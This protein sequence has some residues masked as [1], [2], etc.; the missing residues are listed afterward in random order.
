MDLR[1]TTDPQTF[2]TMS[3]EQLRK[4]FLLDSIFVPGSVQMVY[5]DIDRSITGSVI[6]LL[7]PLQLLSSKR[8]MAA[9]YFAERREIGILNIGGDAFVKIE[10]VQYHLARKDGIY[11]G[12]GA[13][14]IVFSSE[15]PDDPAAF[16]FV[17][18]PAHSVYPVTMI[19]SADATP[20][21]LGSRKDA[22]ERT[23]YKYIYPGSVKSCQ[24][25]MGMTELDEGSVW[26]TMPPH[27][28]TRRSE[29]YMYFGLPPGA[30][31]F[32]M[33]GQPGETRHIVMRD[34]QA[35]LSPSWS[36]HAGVGTSAY[37]FVWSMGGENQ[38]FDDM[39]GVN[40]TDVR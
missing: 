23:I 10:G 39:D 36:I 14:E 32:H 8:E 35:V 6:P 4:V 29:I 28:H 9:D 13:K 2:R 12:R 1:F 27:T 19:K 30:V 25:V 26:N 34:R 16:Y 17:S 7:Q 22:N 33:M 21:R 40:L 20:T 15:K 18:Y 11:I 31:V 37:S 3:Q 38:A 24:L 5:S